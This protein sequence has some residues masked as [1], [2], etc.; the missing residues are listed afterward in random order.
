MARDTARD[1]PWDDEEP[2]EVGD[3]SVLDAFDEYIPAEEPDDA[4]DPW[5]TPEPPTR[6][7]DTVT[8]VLFTAAN[9]DGTV[10]VT[11]LMG[12][13]ILRVDLSPQV[14]RMTESEL[15]EE[16]TVIAGLAR[17]QAQAGQHVLIALIM[18]QQGHDPA[19]TQSFLE[20]DLGLP[21]PSTVN[22]QR[23]SIFAAR[24]AD[25]GSS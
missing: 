12:G 9:P 18:R 10:S 13:Q 6:D 2:I 24:Y 11:A 5:D 3:D 25:H 4:A 14:T 7:D 15:A 23:A 16:V 22:A 17:R 8:T 21:S 19:S 20:R 1:S